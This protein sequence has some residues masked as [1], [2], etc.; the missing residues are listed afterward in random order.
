MAESDEQYDALG[1]EYERVKYIPT[2]LCERATFLSALPD[3]TGKSVLDVACGT[4][5][6]PR[7]FVSLGAERVVGVDSSQEMVSYAQYVEKRD[8]QGIVYAQYDAVTLPLLGSF[9]VVTAVWLLG[10]AE[11]EAALDAMVGNLV[12][13]VAPG[14]TLAVLFPNPDADFDLLEDY[15]KYGYYMSRG[16][17]SLGRQ[18]VVVHVLGESEFSFDSFFWPPGVV[19]LA[20]SRAGLTNVTRHPTVVPEDAVASYGEEFWAQLRVSPS[21]AVLTAT[22]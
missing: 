9:D 7:Q 22:R 8:Q 21:F 18:G 15:Q 11:G 4:G 2:G 20:L 1:K 14:G 3:L 12:A 17:P 19:D 13:N 5:F 6:Y 10:Y 16:E